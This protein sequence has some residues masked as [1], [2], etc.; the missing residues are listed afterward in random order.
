MSNGGDDMIDESGEKKSII[1]VEAGKIYFGR[2]LERKFYFILTALV[3]VWG[4]L[5]KTGLIH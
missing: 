5:V 3:L 4:L 2:E 1:R